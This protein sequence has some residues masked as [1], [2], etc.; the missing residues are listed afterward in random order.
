MLMT[1]DPGVYSVQIS[2]VDGTSGIALAEI[3]EVP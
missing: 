2:S 1:L 3:Y